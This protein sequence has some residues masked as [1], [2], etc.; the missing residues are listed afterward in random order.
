M[1]VLLL[2]GEGSRLQGFSLSVD[3]YRSRFGSEFRDKELVV[4]KRYDGADFLLSALVLEEEFLGL[5]IDLHHSAR[6]ETLGPVEGQ[7]YVA[8]W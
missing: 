7:Q 2:A 1:G 6:W 8:V 5:A 4:S 3:D